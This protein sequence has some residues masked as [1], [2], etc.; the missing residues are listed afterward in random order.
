MLSVAGVCRVV[1]STVAVARVLLV[2]VLR[3]RAHSFGWPKPTVKCPSKCLQV[4]EWI[5]CGY[6]HSLVHPSVSLRRSLIEGRSYKNADSSAILLHMEQRMHTLQAASPQAAGAGANA[7]N[8]SCCCCCRCWHS[9]GL[10]CAQCNNMERRPPTAHSAAH[11]DELWLHWVHV[12]AAICI[13]NELGLQSVWCALQCSIMQLIEQNECC[14][15]W[16]NSTTTIKT[17]SNTLNI[18][19]KAKILDLRVAFHKKGT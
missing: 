3:Q 18:L 16:R 4:V 1:P 7:A 14:I 10:R 6:S 11:N 17:F 8:C 2:I 5:A 9:P 12:W 13:S 19:S 15:I